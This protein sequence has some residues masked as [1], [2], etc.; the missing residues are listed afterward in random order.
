MIANA[1]P[2]ANLAAC[3]DEVRAAIARVLDSGRY[4]LG[5]E[6]AAFER[7]FAAW[8]GCDSCVTV[9]N[10]TD[11][12]ELALRAVGLRAGEGVVLPANTV[13]ATIAAAIAAADSNIENVEY[14]ER[15]LAAATLLFAIEV[16]NRKHLADVIRRVRRTGVVSGAYR[17]PL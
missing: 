11:A 10:G 12:I 17:Y 8:L 5:P 3:A 4:I 9:A 15:D 6:V 2:K 16:K 7:E 1:D 14:A 13:S